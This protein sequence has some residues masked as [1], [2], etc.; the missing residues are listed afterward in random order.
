MARI[1]PC[2]L[3]T[4]GPWGIAPFAVAILPIV[5][6]VIEDS[7]PHMGHANLV[8]IGKGQRKTDPVGRVLSDHIQFAAGVPGG[9]FHSGQPGKISRQKRFTSFKFLLV[10]L[11]NSTLNQKKFQ[12]LR[13]SSPRVFSRSPRRIQSKMRSSYT[14]L[15][16]TSRCV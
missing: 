6:N 8:S 15:L 9:L 7:R 5:Q 10:Y 16:Y 13:T 14:C 12:P 3:Y 1:S 11:D 2:L 4:S